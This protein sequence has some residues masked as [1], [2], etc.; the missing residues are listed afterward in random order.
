MNTQGRN[1]SIQK[2]IQK[3]MLAELYGPMNEVN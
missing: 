3:S 1:Q 2:L